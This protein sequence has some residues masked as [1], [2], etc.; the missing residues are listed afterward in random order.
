MATRDKLL[1]L[2]P[3]GGA[4]DYILEIAGRAGIT[5]LLHTRLGYG[6]VRGCAAG[7]AGQVEAR[8]EDGVRWQ[9]DHFDLE[10][11][12]Y[13]Y[14]SAH[15]RTVVCA[16]VMETLK[17]DPMYMMD[18]IHRVLR[19]GCDLV[20]ATRRYT[21][22]QIRGLLENCGMEVVVVETDGDGVYAVGRKIGPLRERY[23]GWL[24]SK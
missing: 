15:F 9:L 7:E 21:A 22:E 23:P 8:E 16:G 4:E 6:H 13:P 19:P 20:F 5:A 3:A 12:F 10:R 1:S 11:D 24:Y 18:E 2:I 17:H 14:P